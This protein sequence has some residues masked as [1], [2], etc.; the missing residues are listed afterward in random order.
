M[1]RAAL[2]LILALCAFT[3]RLAKADL[4]QFAFEPHPGAH[5]PLAT[6]LLDEHGRTVKLGAFFGGHPV[7]LV[8][9]YLRCRSLC[10]VTLDS[11]IKALKALPLKPGRD[12]DLVAISID[13]RDTPADASRAQT[14][15]AT[16]YGRSGGSGFHFLTGNTKAVR[17]IATDV[18]FPYKFEARLGTYIHPAGFMVVTP[19]GDVS[20][21]IEGVG[22]KPQR[23]VRA[24]A[25]AQ[26]LKYLGPLARII[27]FCHV[28]GA[29][30]G[31]FTVP[32]LAV[33]MIADIAGGFALIILFA[34]IRRRRHG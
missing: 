16:E 19:Q 17:Q 14:K 25:D 12:F 2:F 9:E 29:P 22:V 1:R 18:G 8:L 15:Y 13:P 26:Q 3:P 20:S 6:K 4:S 27:L 32:V 34:S 24:I 5:L 11:I 23:L 31:R 30:L 21:Y 28:Q 7:I 10:G 33:F